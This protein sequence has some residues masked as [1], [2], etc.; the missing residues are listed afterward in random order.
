MKQ[1]RRFRLHDGKSGSAITIRVTPRM[2]KN[3]IY[4]I[5]DDGT[6]KIRLTAPPVDGKS[7]KELAR[8]LAEVLE[9]PVS[10]IEIIAGLSGHDKIVSILDLDTV[11]VQEKILKHLAGK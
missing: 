11:Q 3:E 1:K 4:D 6:V 7:N 9:V 5:L 8:F 2:A 10:S